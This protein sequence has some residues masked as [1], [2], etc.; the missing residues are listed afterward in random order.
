MNQIDYKSEA[1][2]ANIFRCLYFVIAA[3][4][5]DVISKILILLYI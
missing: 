1:F 5:F 2:S 4:W 3:K